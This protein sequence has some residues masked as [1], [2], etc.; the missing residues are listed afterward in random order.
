M[1]KGKLV[2]VPFP[3]DDFSATKVRPALCLTDPIGSFRHVVLAFLTSQPVAP[4]LDT[5]LEL[6]PSHPDFPT[7]GLNGRGTI[8]LH[9]FGHDDHGADSPGVGNLVPSPSGGG[10]YSTAQDIQPVKPKHLES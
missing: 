1:T 5:D 2:L 4:L 6:E 8:R 9:R 7:T 3:F 10:R